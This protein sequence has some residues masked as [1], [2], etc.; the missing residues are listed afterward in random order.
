MSAASERFGVV[1][2]HTCCGR[3]DGSDR[4]S[5]S[6]GGRQDQALGGVHGVLLEESKERKMAR[7]GGYEEGG[8]APGVDARFVASHD[9]PLTA[10][11]VNPRLRVR[12]CW[13]DRPS[14]GSSVRIVTPTAR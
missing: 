5:E 10:A 13:V 8:A 7:P 3:T 9:G 11:A 2:G 12:M 4:E 1:D 14:A 6:G